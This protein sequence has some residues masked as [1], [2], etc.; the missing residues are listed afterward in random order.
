MTTY[1]TEQNEDD[2]SEGN[3]TTV[4]EFN[5]KVSSITDRFSSR[6][7]LQCHNGFAD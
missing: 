5:I 2:S 1:A 6:E 3:D 7:T 4:V